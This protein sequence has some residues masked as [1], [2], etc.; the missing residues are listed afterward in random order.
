V[1]GFGDRRAARS[2]G[3]RELPCSTRAGP[4]WTLGGNRFPRNSLLDQLVGAGE[5]RWWDCEAE[6]LRAHQIDN[7][8]NLGG[9]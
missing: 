4:A 1:I 6:R 3:R 7:Q 2:V 5:Q 9:L 8:L